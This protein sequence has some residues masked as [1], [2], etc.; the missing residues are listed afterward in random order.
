[1][2]ATLRPLAT[3]AGE[4]VAGGADFRRA[5]LLGVAFA[6]DFGGIA[7]PIGTGPNLIAIGAVEGLRP[8]TFLEWMTFGVPLATVMLLAACAMLVW[9]YRV[10]GKIE[11]VPTA[12]APLSPRGWVVVAIFFAAVAGWLTEPLHGVSTALVALAVA[13]A[14]FAG[15]LLDRRDLLKLE[16]DTLLLVAGGLAL[17]ELFHRSGLA[18]SL[19][20]SARWELLP[21]PVLLLAM[22]FAC[23][24]ISAVASNTAA[25]AMLTQIALGL[26]PEPSVAV[27]VALGA[28]MGVPFVISTPPNTMAYGQGGLRTR[29]FFVPGILLMLGGCGIVAF[30]V[31]P[32]LKWIGIP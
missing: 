8:I 12:A 14:L 9:R 1:M 2:V 16:W 24:L 4:G 32:V 3:A 11:R 13:G 19:A 6:A 23:A 22:A 26:M 18:S 31:P 10:A 28:S 27:V 7:T 30:A 20:S 17:G 25:A 15:G 21:R 5:L 29:D